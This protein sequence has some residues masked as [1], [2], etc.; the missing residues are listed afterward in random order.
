MLLALLLPAC[1][2]GS[3]VLDDGSG[4]PD[5]IEEEEEVIEEEE[6]ELEPVSYQAE[7]V[8]FNE[9][10]G[11]EYCLGELTLTLEDGVLTGEGACASES[12]WVS[13][14]LITIDA[15]VED[16]AL[17]GAGAVFYDAGWGDPIEEE[18]ELDGEADEDGVELAFEIEVE[19]GGGYS[20]QF[21]FTIEGDAD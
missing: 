1:N 19:Y 21:V 2:S 18:G 4:T 14:T 9:N 17:D 3:V 7:L 16:D 12:G 20:D 15:E 5:E 13:D 10:W 6:E 11:G 8:G